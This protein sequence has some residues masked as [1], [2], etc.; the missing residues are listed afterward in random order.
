MR[1]LAEF[2]MRG[3]WQALAVAILGAGSLLFGWVSAAA[4]ALV[5]L[6][7]GTS[8]GGWV[9]LWALLPALLV[10]WV[11]G[12]SGSVLLLGGTFALAVIL[13]TSVNLPLAV[14]ASSLVGLISGASL[15]LLS[16][17]FLEQLVD[18]FEVVLEQVAASLNT[19][20][21]S[22]IALPAPTAVQIAG[23]L[24]GGNAATAVLS[25]LLAR[26]WQ[27]ALYNPGGFRREFYALRL[28]KLWTLIFA[29]AGLALWLQPSG[30]SSW[31]LMFLVPLSFYGFSLAHV[32]V[33]RNQGSNGRLVLFYCLWLLFD[34]IK[35]VVLALVL[36]DAI[37][38]FR[39]RWTTGEPQ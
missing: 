6:R 16:G 8:E 19:G 23:I 37:V 3:R 9:V 20:S 7:K 13:R 14:A 21:E 27:A 30:L 25:L 12:D 24:A 18:V 26:Y 1:G 11:S 17:D 4:V 29:G 10:A 5:T 34:P 39:A 36:V 32:W 31:A 38:D 15:L 33:S 35:G 2:I 28:P 22:A